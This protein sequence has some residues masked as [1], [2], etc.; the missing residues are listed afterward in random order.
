MRR[1]VILVWAERA[2]F[3]T[4]RRARSRYVYVYVHS[5][6]PK[7]EGLYRYGGVADTTHTT[8]AVNRPNVGE[9]EAPSQLQC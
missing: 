1:V 4:T 6:P 7:H 2:S 9:E 5:R 3:N 8:Q